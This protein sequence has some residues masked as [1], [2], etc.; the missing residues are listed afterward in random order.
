MRPNRVQNKEQLNKDAT[1]WENTAH[2]NARN[3]FC[4]ED[5]LWNLPLDRISAD[6]MLNR[7][8]FVA[9]ESSEE[10]KRNR[11]TEPKEENNDKRSKWNSYKKSVRLNQIK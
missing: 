10:G 5:L 8:L 11:N 1:E 2:D 6:G 3:W 9:V 7:T 4:V